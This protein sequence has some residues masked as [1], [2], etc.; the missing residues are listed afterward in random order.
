MESSNVAGS[1]RT[2]EAALDDLGAA[3][4]E[5]R[6]E[7]AEGYGLLKIEGEKQ[8]AYAQ[9]EELLTIVL[10]RMHAASR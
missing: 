9:A 1:Y 10:E 2:V 3:V 8:T 7:A 4:R 5:H 6:L